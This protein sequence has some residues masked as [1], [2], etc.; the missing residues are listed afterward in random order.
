[1]KHTHDDKPFT[2]PNP[3]AIAT[4]MAAVG[5][6]ALP[7]GRA[8]CALV[9]TLAPGAYTAVVSGV[10]GTSGVALVEVYQAP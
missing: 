4:E 3:A 2:A 7:S 5:A 1:M 6:F 10:N 9:L 8:D